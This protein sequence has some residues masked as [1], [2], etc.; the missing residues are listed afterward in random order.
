[1]VDL[2]QFGTGNEETFRA[3]LD[4]E[5]KKLKRAFPRRSRKWGLARKLLNIFLR[6]CAY[7]IYLAREYDLHLAEDFFEIPLDSITAR[8]LKRV[9]AHGNLPRWPGVKHVT[10]RLSRRFQLAA[11]QQ[12][13]KRGIARLHLDALLW[14][15]LRDDNE[16]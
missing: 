14:P 15:V 2:S 11:Q 1:L 5:T 7:T 16:V 4:N 3:A 9:T 8:G 12:A 13:Q 6:D 10:P